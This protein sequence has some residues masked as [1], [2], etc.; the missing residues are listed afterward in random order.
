MGPVRPGL[1]LGLLALA[2]CAGSGRPAARL[3]GHRAEIYTIDVGGRQRSFILAPG[4]R[5]TA[6]KPLML[7]YHGAGGTA[8]A[9]LDQTALGLAGVNAGMAVASLDAA[10]GTDGRWFVNVAETGPGDDVAFTMAAIAAIAKDVRIDS[11]RILAV[12]YSRGAQ[13]TYQ[14]AC[15]KPEI[16]RAIVAVAGSLSASYRPWCDASAG[17]PHPAVMLA[18]GTRDPAMAGVE[19][20]AR[21]ISARN[22]CAGT[23]LDSIPARRA[24]W[25]VTRTR[26]APCENG[27]VVF[28][29]IDPLAHLWPGSTF[30]VEGALVSWFLALPRR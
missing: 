4:H 2:A 30:D 13:F 12:G 25:K 11:T 17:A 29:R 5:S 3:D 6:P 10:P 15:R 14:L 9:V 18:S 16:V 28:Y 23:A 26:F 27:D 1:T 21:F 7:I 19:Q 22:A 20:T 24:T 8:Q